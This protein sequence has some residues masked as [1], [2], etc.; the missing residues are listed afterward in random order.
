MTQNTT[1]NIVSPNN[2]L[3]IL[4]ANFP[5]CF[6]KSGNFDFEKFKKELQSK[7]RLVRAGKKIQAEQKADLF[8]GDNKQDF[9]FKIF[10]T[11]PIWE[12]YEFK[13]EEFDPQQELFDETKLTDEDLQ[14]LLTT[15]KTY[16]NIALTVD[17]QKIDLG[18]YIG[19]YSDKK[20]Y[21]M[22]KGFQTEHLKQLLEAIDSNKDF[23][24]A[25]IIVFGYHFDSK[26]LREIAENVASYA[27]KK[28]LDIDF[29]TRY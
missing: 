20:L 13:A 1:N 6:E 19:H 10:E 4:K 18:G 15:W 7:E 25:I 5:H 27:N 9:G 14:T 24:P 12:D 21:L 3:A 26:N 2:D 29:I 11:M 23:S 8:T 22:D 17:L 28:K 16:D